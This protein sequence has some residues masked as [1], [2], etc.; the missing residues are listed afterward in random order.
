MERIE[1]HI[2]KKEGAQIPDYATG[3]SSGVDLRA[4]IEDPVVLKP[5]ERF[6]IPTGISIGI[7][8]DMKL[9]YDRGAAWL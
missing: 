2:A 6:L 9:K 3:A 5:L 7:P 4:F 1:V 8:K